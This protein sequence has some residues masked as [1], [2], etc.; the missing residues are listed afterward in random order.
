MRRCLIVVVLCVS[1]LLPTLTA[2]SH[3][4]DNPPLSKSSTASRLRGE[5]ACSQCDCPKYSGQ[6]AAGKF[7]QN[8]GCMHAC[9]LHFNPSTAL[10]RK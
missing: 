10:E 7:C 5:G 9:E 4:G 6:Q 1:V 8:E 3:Q 2:W